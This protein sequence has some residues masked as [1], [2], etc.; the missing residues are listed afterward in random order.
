MTD[1]Q[2]SSDNPLKYTHLDVAG[3]AGG[4]PDPPTASTVVALSMHLLKKEQG[5]GVSNRW[6]GPISAKGKGLFGSAGCLVIISLS[7]HFFL[8]VNSY[9]VV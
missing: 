6:P 1:H 2:I 9:F 4:Y 3:S 8:E 5:V 7:I